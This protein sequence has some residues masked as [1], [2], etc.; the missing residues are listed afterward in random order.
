LLPTVRPGQFQRS[1]DSIAPAAGE[2]PYEIIVVADFD[3]PKDLSCGKWLKRERKGPIAA[4]NT[5]FKRSSGDYLF[6]MNDE[7]TLDPGAL[8]LLYYTAL[9][10]PRCIYSPKHIPE[11]GFY[12]YGK[13]FAAFPFVRRDVIF[14]LGG[15]IFDPAYKGFYADPDFSMRAYAANIP[16][17]VVEGAI[18]R[19]GNDMNAPGH[20]ENV[21]NFLDADRALFRL[22]WDHLGEFRDP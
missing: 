20:Q 3:C 10:F 17:R 9:G 14:E 1:F 16:I 6:V 11:F 21:S 12:Y 13:H 18:L 4:I 15:F 2:V 7:S 22:R 8:A 5:A 19:H